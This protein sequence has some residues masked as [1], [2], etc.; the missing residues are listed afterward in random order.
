MRILEKLYIEGFIVAMLGAVAL[1]WLL[2]LSGHAGE[3][4]SWTTKFAV[5]LLS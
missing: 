4:L 1:G 3:I 2:P 5:G